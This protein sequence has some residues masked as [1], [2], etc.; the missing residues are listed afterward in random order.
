MTQKMTWDKIKRTFPN[1][2]VAITSL[3]GDTESPFGAICGEVFLHD[4][5]ENE[6][7]EQLKKHS[8]NQLIDIRFT[9]EVLPDHPIGPILWQISD[10]NS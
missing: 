2:W 8:I 3:D 10:T 4:K 9:G 7:T 1:E 6:F 5:N